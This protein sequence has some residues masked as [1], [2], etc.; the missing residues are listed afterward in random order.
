MKTSWEWLAD[1]VP[2]PDKPVELAEA[3]TM[4]GLE[5]ESVEQAIPVPEGVV[6][7]EIRRREAHPDADNLSLVYIDDGSGEDQQVVCG[8]P[9]CHP[10]RMVPFAVPGTVLADGMKVKKAKLRGQ[11]SAG[12]LCS[13]RELGISDD[14]T[15]LMEL[16]DDA[17][18][19]TAVR[20]LVAGGDTII[21]WEITPNRP[22]WLSHYGIARETAAVFNCAEKL[23]PPPL[24]EPAPSSVSAEDVASVRIEAPDLCP[25]YTARIVRGVTVAE[26]PAWLKRRLEAVGIRPINNIVDITNYVLMEC[27]QPLHAFDLNL[28]SQNTVVVRRAAENET[29]TTLD[30]EHRELGPDNLMIADPEQGI[31]LAGVM[32]GTNTEIGEKTSD[33][34]LESA[35][36]Q[37]A[38]IR[39]TA[40]DMGV[41]TDS[42]YR[43]ERGVSLQMVDYASRRAASLIVQLAGGELL[44]GAVDAYPQPPASE[45]VNCRYDRVNRLLGAEISPD[46]INSYLKRLGLAVADENEESVTVEVPDFRLDLHRE[47]DIVEEIAR[48]HGIENIAA[49]PAAAQVGGSMSDDPYYD[50]E[51]VRYAMLAGGLDEAMNYTLT[52]PEEAGRCTGLQEE[53]MVEVDNPISREGAVLRPSL[54]PGLITNAATNVARGNVDIR[55]FETGRVFTRQTGWPEERQQLGI[56]LSGRRYPERY[57]AEGGEQIDFYDLKGILEGWL[58]N[59]HINSLQWRPATHPAL[60]STCAAELLI[61]G[62]KMG[63][64]GEISGSLTRE[65]RLKYPLYV[66]LIELNVLFEMPAPVCKYQPLP[67]F[68]ATERDISMIVPAGEVNNE[69]IQRE[70]RKGATELMEAVDLTDVYQDDSLSAENKKSM[71]YTVTYRAPDRTVTDEEINEIHERVRKHLAEALPVQLR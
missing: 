29:I 17:Q 19:G 54:L 38:N 56:M 44:N 34:L 11:K 48:I 25:R 10:G 37:P 26:S 33:V 71:T 69:Q 40:R 36:F 5:V 14:H 53:Q 47:A 55:L 58:L 70:I 43:F 35:A 50:L 60:A 31:A 59:R 24:N 22:D 27:G 61:N 8:A 46:H 45:Q 63:V 66:A 21:D 68:P 13:E 1:Y 39:A 9:N 62:E 51:Q 42:S 23:S 7:A 6:V 20:D 65:M 28:V 18:P 15:G 57:G 49:S 2:L 16:A 41:Q 4:A 30:G 12:M 64:L 67:Q 3:L 32:G 52:S